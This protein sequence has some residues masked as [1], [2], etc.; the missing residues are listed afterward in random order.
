M[1]ISIV[2]PAAMLC[3][4]S[5][6]VIHSFGYGT[7]SGTISI[8]FPAQEK[9]ETGVDTLEEIT[10]GGVKQWILIQGEDKTNPVLLTLHGGPGFAEMPYT[11]VCSSSLKKHFVVVDWDQRG[12]G[13]SF[14]PDI[15][16]E[17]MNIEQLLSDTHMLIQ[18]LKSRFSKD[19]IFLVGHSW[20]SVLGL[21]T[22]YKHPE[23][24]HAYIGMGQV[25][26]MREGEIV[27]YEYT[28]G[29]A[30]EAG[31][32]KAIDLLKKIGAPP[33]AG[34]L[35]SL[36]TQRMLLAKYGGSVRNISLTDLDEIRN[37][38]PFYT[39]DDNE[40]YMKAFM[41]TISLM[42]DNLQEVDFFEEV[43]EVRVPVYFFTGRYDYQAPF[44][45][46]ERYFK[47][48]KAPYKE[49]V[50]FENSGHMPNLEEPEVYQKMIIQIERKYPSNKGVSR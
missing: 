21:Y 40:N 19:R 6:F 29:K 34:G 31:D 48:L 37:A 4:L 20:G 28:L 30:K 39:K 16:E 22:A 43:P 46:L 12:A 50:W 13:K 36:F 25:V 23:D 14:D 33:Y 44:E 27:T 41:R 11:H 10:L 1:R 15:P 5:L 18:M 24:L 2:I 17:T 49:I 3:C 47:E 8:P 26:N 45:L 35:Q 38:S 32:E 42:W 9:S 7:R